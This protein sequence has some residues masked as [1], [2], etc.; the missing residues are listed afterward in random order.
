MTL[1][2]P[3]QCRVGHDT[4]NEVFQPADCRI[5]HCLYPCPPNMRQAVGSLHCVII[6]VIFCAECSTMWQVSYKK[7]K[8]FEKRHA[9]TTSM[10]TG[11]ISK[12]EG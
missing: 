3:M 7:R 9:Y 2:L 8:K 10:T 6:W 12:S 4:S 1:G 11:G 5:L